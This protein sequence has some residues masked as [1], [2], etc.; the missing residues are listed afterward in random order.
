[1]NNPIAFV[2]FIS[3]WTE[4]KAITRLLAELFEYIPEHEGDAAKPCLQLSDTADIQLKNLTFH[5]PGRIELLQDLSVNIPGGQAI[6]LIGKSGCGKSTL[7]KLLTRLYPLQSGEIYIGDY[8]LSELPLDCLRQQVVLVPQDSFFLHRS[9]IDNFRL[10]VPHATVE[11]IIAACRIAG[12]DEFIS[13]FPEQ[14]DTILGVVGA[15]ISGGQKQRIAIARALLNNPPILIL[16][17]STANLDPITENEV[18]DRILAH[19]RGKTTIL[20]SHRPQVIRR[21]DW[22]VMLNQGE[23]EFNGKTEEFQT[24]TLEG[25]T[26]TSKPYSARGFEVQP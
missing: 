7:S 21:A 17:E 2:K 23:L 12:A 25:V 5:Y 10:S 9:I 11:D 6:V 3:E 19:R 20:I 24:A 8:P 14:Y 26:S 13:Q 15:N 22:L 4:I 18:L 16:D 1:M